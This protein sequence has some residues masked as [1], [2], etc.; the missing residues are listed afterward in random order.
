MQNTAL[1]KIY[2]W[3]LNSP[4][5]YQLQRNLSRR[6]CKNWQRKCIGAAL[7]KR[8]G[9]KNHPFTKKKM[10]CK[11][12]FDFMWD[13]SRKVGEVQRGLTCTL[14]KRGKCAISPDPNLEVWVSYCKKLGKITFHVSAKASQ[15]CEMWSPDTVVVLHLLLSSGQFGSGL[16]FPFR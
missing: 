5:L 11:N 8:F 9:E 12:Y 14:N 6:L 4:I 2:L 16:Y 3:I 10:F 13:F 15:N 1:P 7:I